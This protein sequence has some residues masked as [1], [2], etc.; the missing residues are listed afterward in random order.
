VPAPAPAP[1]GAPAPGATA[2]PAPIVPLGPRPDDADV[3]KKSADLYARDKEGTTTYQDRVFPLA[4]IYSILASGDVTTGQGAEQLNRARSILETMG[5][6]LGWTDQT[7][8]QAKFDDLTKYMQQYVNKQ[9]MAARS[10]QALAS[11]I[12]GSPSAHLSTLANKD[13][14]K[15]LIA[16]ER[17][18]QMAMTDFENSNGHPN[19]YSKFLG[20][21]Q[22]THDPRAFMV[23]LLDNKQ[24][25]K[26]LAGMNKNDRIRFD[27]TL[28]L[29]EGN[30]GILSL[31][32][33]PH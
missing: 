8:N 5:A 33:M 24:I 15:P 1:P 12:T 31:S 16:M 29:V 26:M 28:K 32:I 13:V 9:G 20:D 3:W 17:M 7:T 25:D 27:K 21:W 18:K 2:A 10:D 4:Q 30:Q 14:V 23:D 22:N 19:D 11:A 6:K